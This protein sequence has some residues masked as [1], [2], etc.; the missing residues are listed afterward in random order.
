VKKYFILSILM[1][2]LSTLGFADAVTQI[3]IGVGPAI[4]TLTVAANIQ[5]SWYS[6]EIRVGGGFHVNSVFIFY[7]CL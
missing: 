6:P 7:V 2:V 3:D 5:G 1:V 4:R